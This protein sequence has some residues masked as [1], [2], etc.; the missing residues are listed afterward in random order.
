[1]ESDV[2][3]RQKMHLARSEGEPVQPARLSAAQMPNG[4]INVRAAH[5]IRGGRD[6]DSTNTSSVGV[7]GG[8]SIEDGDVSRRQLAVCSNVCQWRRDGA[9]DDGG[10]NSQY[11]LC[12]YGTDCFDCGIRDGYND[13]YDPGSGGADECPSGDGSGC[14]CDNSCYGSSSSLL[15]YFF[16]LVRKSHRPRPE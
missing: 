5:S 3:L 9:C 12:T 11:S 13:Y 16:L 1:M 2:L 6:D 14:I 10:P 4:H 15:F 7:G 8:S